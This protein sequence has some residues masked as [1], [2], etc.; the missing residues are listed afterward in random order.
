LKSFDL[1]DQTFFSGD[2]TAEVGL[3]EAHFK[4]LLNEHSLFSDEYT[5]AFCLRS[6]LALQALSGI[7][8]LRVLERA[9]P[10]QRDFCSRHAVP[11]LACP[12]PRLSQHVP[13]LAAA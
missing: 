5:A 12:I 3:V 10:R 4:P 2:P 13:P 7:L 11:L 9:G 8:H 6:M 1:L